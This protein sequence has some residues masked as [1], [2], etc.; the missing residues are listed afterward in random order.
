MHGTLTGELFQYTFPFPSL[1]A[2]ES[3]SPNNNNI[4]SPNKCILIGG[5]SDGLLPT[6]Y[7]SELQ[8]ICHSKNWSLVQPILSSSYLGFGHGSLTRDTKELEQLIYYLIHH[9]NASNIA[10]IGHSTGCQNG[11]HFVN[12]ADSDLVRKIKFIALQAPVSDREHAMEDDN[13]ESNLKVAKDMYDNGKQE[14]MMPRNVFWAPITASRFVNLFEKYGEDDLFSS[15]FSNDEL[16]GKLGL[17]GKYYKSGLRVLVAFSKKDGYVPKNIDKEDLVKRLCNA[18]NSE[19][20]E[21]ESVARA[22]LLEGGNHNLSVKIDRE[23]FLEHVEEELKNALKRIE[24][25]D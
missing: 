15:D 24:N 2:F 6:P 17:F 25:E 22:I 12:C 14:E 21:G 7:T 13:Y 5:L 10:L 8:S 1:V 16:N 3:L 18:M 11:V 19:C 20:K 23:I 9:R 4:L